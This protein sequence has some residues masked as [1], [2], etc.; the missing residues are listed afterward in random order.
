MTTNAAF[1]RA[2]LAREDVRAG[3]QDTGLL[4]RVLA[5]LRVRAAGR[6]AAR[7][8]ARRRP[9]DTAGRRRPGP[10]R[11]ALASTARCA[12]SGG[13]GDARAGGRGR[14]GR[15]RDRAATGRVRVT[16]DGVARA[17]RRRAS[18]DDAVLDRPRRPPARGAHRAPPRA[19]ARGARWPARSRRRCPARSCSSTSPTATRVEEGDVLLVLES[20]KME[21]AITAPHAGHRRRAST[22]RP[23]D[24]VAL[25]QPLV[26]VVAGGGGMSHRDGHLELI[27][28]LERAARA[29]ARRR[30]AERAVERHVARGKLLVARARRAALRPGRA[31]PRALAAGRRGALRRRRARRG[32]RHRRRR[33]SAGGAASSSPTTRR[34][35]AAPTTR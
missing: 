19:A 4:E 3:E 15:R 20:M 17:L 8:R 32:H 2:L 35:R 6:P 29:R 10:W 34:S 18:S 9:A 14:R 11:R 25:R 24:R 22:L 27:A 26:A 23:G 30:R 16:L 7:R 21:L 33:R 12:S 1:T 13:R 31:V 28:D 5:E